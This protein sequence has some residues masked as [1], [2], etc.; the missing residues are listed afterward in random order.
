[1][2]L[3]PHMAGGCKHVVKSTLSPPLKSQHH[4]NLSERGDLKILKVRIHEI[5]THALKFRL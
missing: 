3:D 5:N 1:M 4:N 2:A